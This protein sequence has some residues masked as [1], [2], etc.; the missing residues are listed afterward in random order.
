MWQFSQFIP[1]QYVTLLCWK[2]NLISNTACLKCLNLTKKKRTLKQLQYQNIVLE[3]VL[4]GSEQKHVWSAHGCRK[5]LHAHAPTDKDKKKKSPLTL[6]VLNVNN[7]DCLKIKRNTWEK[8]SVLPSVMACN[9]RVQHGLFLPV[10]SWETIMC[11]ACD[12]TIYTF[13]LKRNKWS[14]TQTAS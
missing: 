9:T 5:G 8:I 10:T 11:I 2:E 1:Y 7:I 3:E 13:S 14:N 4:S 12:C 6:N